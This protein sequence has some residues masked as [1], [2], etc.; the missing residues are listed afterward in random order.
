MHANCAIQLCELCKLCVL[1]VGHLACRSRFCHVWQNCG[2]R[3]CRMH[4]SNEG[5]LLDQAVYEIAILLSLR[6][7]PKHGV[8]SDLCHE[9][10]L[11]A[12]AV[13]CAHFVPIGRTFSRKTIHVKRAAEEGEREKGMEP[14]RWLLHWIA[15][16]DDPVSQSV[17]VIAL[18]ANG[19]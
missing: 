8:G 19:K 10:V 2:L 11:I 9:I 16:P 5:T 4:N 14:V 12:K 13:F 15:F 1:A 17:H 3:P 18:I 7:T 6:F